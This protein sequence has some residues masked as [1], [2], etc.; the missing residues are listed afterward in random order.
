MS[1][2]PLRLIVT[3]RVDAVAGRDELREALDLNLNHWLQALGALPF[4]VSC[5]LTPSALAN[6]LA[7]VDGDGLLLSGGNDIGSCPARDQLELALLDWA[8]ERGKP[9][10]G[11]CRGMQLLAHHAGGTLQPCQG[12]VACHHQLEGEL[13]G[14][15]NSYHQQALAACPPGYRLLATSVDG[16]IEAIRHRQRQWEGWMWHPERDQPF[17]PLWLAR[18][19]QLFSEEHP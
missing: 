17:D 1:T 3:Q 13:T 10:L 12:H 6:W 18:A 5:S 15:V 11:I 9:V 16:E 2:R 7:Q 4:A 8:Q 14:R 19:H